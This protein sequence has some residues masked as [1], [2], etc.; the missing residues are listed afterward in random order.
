MARSPSPH[1]K[2]FHQAQLQTNNSESAGPYL[3]YSKQC[4][5]EIVK[6]LP[7][8]WGKI[9][10]FPQVWPRGRCHPASPWAA[11]P[12]VLRF[13][14]VSHAAPRVQL[15]VS[16]C[17]QHTAL[18]AQHA[19]TPRK[20]ERFAPDG[21]H[22]PAASGAPLQIRHKRPYYFSGG[23]CVFLFPITSHSLNCAD[24]IGQGSVI[25][26]F[27]YLHKPGMH[28]VACERRV[29]MHVT[30]ISVIAFCFSAC[31]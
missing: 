25:F 31:R 22:S 1:Q 13:N 30:C 20:S 4:R 23:V 8:S 21:S 5:P 15:S 14:G 6:I 29:K 18:N 24:C 19:A 12:H 11:S 17:L 26:N 2:K 28:K 3:R 27:H 7:S 10:R 16:P 9:T